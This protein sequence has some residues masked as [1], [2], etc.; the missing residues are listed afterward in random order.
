LETFVTAQTK[1]QL[2]GVGELHVDSA[3]IQQGKLVAAKGQFGANDGEIGNWFLRDLS[4]YFGFAMP[5][6]FEASAPA[7]GVTPFSEIRLAFDLRGE[8]LEVAGVADGALVR[9][10]EGGKLLDGK[11]SRAAQA[12]TAVRVLYPMKAVSVPV[13]HESWWLASRL[14]MA[15]AAETPEYHAKPATRPA[16]PPEKAE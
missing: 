6:R 1:Q 5:R 13:S 10:G 4:S 3:E 14:S 15:G 12:H 2:R 7:E 16:T 11:Q 8:A 9:D